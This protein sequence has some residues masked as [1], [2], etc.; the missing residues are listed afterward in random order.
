MKSFFLA[1]LTAT[2]IATNK[3]YSSV[4]ANKSLYLSEYAYCGHSLYD[5]VTWGGPVT[6]FVLKSTIYD[7]ID[8]TN[9]Y[10]GYLPSDNSIY[11]AYRGSESILNWVTNLSTTKTAYTS[12]P[13]C[14][15]QVHE[16]F[17][18]AEQRALS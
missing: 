13:D 12:Y 11:V 17:Y 16:G 2:T 8:D 6:G 9:G 15:C 10:I 3:A 5:Q 4:E 7:I 1:A 18:A 14:N